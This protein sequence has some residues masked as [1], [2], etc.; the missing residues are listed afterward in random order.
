LV[1]PEIFDQICGGYEFGNTPREVKSALLL[2]EWNVGDIFQDLLDLLDNLLGIGVVAGEMI[3]HSACVDDTYAFVVNPHGIISVTTC[4]CC[5]NGWQR[6]VSP[7]HYFFHRAFVWFDS[8]LR[9]LCNHAKFRWC[10]RVPSR[11]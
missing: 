8:G 5:R 4:Y 11:R 3:G 2:A 9:F 7:L 10:G 6:T 1:A